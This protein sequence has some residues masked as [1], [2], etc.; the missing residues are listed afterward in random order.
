MDAMRQ[1]IPLTILSGFLGAGKTTLVNQI[2]KSN[3]GLRIAVVVNDFGS[4][5]IDEQLIVSQDGETIGLANGCV[6]C[7]IGD[8]LMATLLDLLQRPVRPD[9]LII[10][11]SGV[12]DPWKIAQIGLS[13]DAYALDGII[14]LADAETV[15]E[16]AGDK[17]VG[18]TVLRQLSAADIIV[19]NKRDLVSGE[20]TEALRGWIGG[21][22]AEARIV[23]AAH[24]NVPL[25]L[26]LGIDAGRI[27]MQLAQQSQAAHRGCDEHH[28]HGDDYRSWEF[29]ADLPF[30]GDALR[31]ALDMLPDAIIRAKG[32]LY[33]DDDPARRT[34][35]QLVGKRWEL[36]PGTPWAN[37]HPKSQLIF[38]GLPGA[39]DG[40]SLF[41]RLRFAL[42]IRSRL[43]V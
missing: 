26:L 1:P 40:E 28:R 33:L 12:S 17:Y 43:P 18:E 21:V 25:A 24:A 27:G 7:S 4:I 29:T 6:C 19:M 39:V 20:Q 15:V 23:E 13:N 37:T 14:T 16:R 8:S 35:F 11:A 32:V 3:H 5:N 41:A 31:E 42:A 2:L 34:R 38:I 10:E 9:H 30:R 36:T 22:A